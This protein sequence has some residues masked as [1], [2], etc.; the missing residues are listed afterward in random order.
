MARLYLAGAFFNAGQRLHFLFLEKHLKLLGHEVILPL[1]DTKDLIGEESFDFDG[2]TGYC[3]RNVL[4]PTNLVVMN[5]DATD[6]DDTAIVISIAFSPK[7]AAITYRTNIR[8]D[9][10]RK[11]KR[12]DVPRARKRCVL[13]QPAVFTEL[14]EV[15]AYY[16][17]LAS[18]IH[19]FVEHVLRD[20]NAK[21]ATH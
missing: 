6:G 12:G 4:D 7:D 21:Q 5:G 19:D 10:A 13:H 15:D 3:S 8:S 2:L 17:R 9:T 1:R 16:K 11:N 14:E 20:G 18:H